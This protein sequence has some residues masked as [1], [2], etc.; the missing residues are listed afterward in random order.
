ME[1]VGVEAFGVHLT[2]PA[3]P[4]NDDEYNDDADIG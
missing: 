2:S 3:L 4:D 1:M